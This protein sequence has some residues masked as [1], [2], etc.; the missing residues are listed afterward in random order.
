MK[1]NPILTSACFAPYNLKYGLHNKYPHSQIGLSG[2]YF[3]HNLDLYVTD[4]FDCNT[5]PEYRH[6]P[7]DCSQYFRCVDVGLPNRVKYDFRCSPGTYFD[8]QLLLCEFMAVVRDKCINGWDPITEP[9]TTV[10]PTTVQPTTIE[11]T[12]QTEPPATSGPSTPTQTPFTGT[13]PTTIPPTTVFG[14]YILLMKY[15]HVVRCSPE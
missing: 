1:D 15:K 8:P 6:H 12:T 2:L 4:P 7:Q 14:W 3:K 5:G 10:L 13:I 11:V 9:P